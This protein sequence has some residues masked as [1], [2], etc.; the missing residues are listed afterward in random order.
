[1]SLMVKF[2]NI[3]VELSDQ[4]IDEE[5][6]RLSNNYE[7]RELMTEDISAFL[8]EIKLLDKCEFYWKSKK[9][10]KKDILDETDLYDWD[11]SNGD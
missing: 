6:F 11:M 2:G 3:E 1:M 5:S 4:W 7:M 9:N 10:N 8:D